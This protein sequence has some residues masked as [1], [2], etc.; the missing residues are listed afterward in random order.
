MKNKFHKKRIVGLAA[1][2]LCC[3]MILFGCGVG[4]NNTPKRQ[5]DPSTRVP[6]DNGEQVFTI[7]QDYARY[8]NYIELYDGDG[9]IYDIGD[10]YVFRFNGKYY[11]YTSLN[12]NKKYSGKIPCWESDNMVDWKWS[13][14]AYDPNSTS[15]SSETYIAFAP[16]IVYYKGWFYMCESRRGQGHYFFRSATPN[17]PF[18]LISDN[19]GMGIDGSFYLSRRRATLFRKRE[20]RSFLS[21]LL[22]HR[23]PRRRFGQSAGEFRQS[24]ENRKRKLKRL[25]GGTR[26]F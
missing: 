19:L 15:Q 25:D 13:G 10:P 17:G 22:H 6:T 23:F 2:M 21:Y 4:N 1:A 18:T 16:E 11:L 14:W 8:N 24:A 20:R 3:S 12:G 26:V 7:D 9:D 5:Y